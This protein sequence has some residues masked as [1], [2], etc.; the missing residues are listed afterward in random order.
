MS[1]GNLFHFSFPFF[2]SS[3]DSYSFDIIS[4]LFILKE[5]FCNMV[6]LTPLLNKYFVIL[7]CPS[8]TAPYNK[9]YCIFFF[10]LYHY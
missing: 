5:N 3:I 4:L 10:N 8:F 6:F 7:K 9:V 1:V 2:N